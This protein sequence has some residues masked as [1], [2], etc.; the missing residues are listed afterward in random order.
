M[1]MPAKFLRPFGLTCALVLAAACS[2]PP[3]Q[4]ELT[5]EKAPPPKA[6]PMAQ[7]LAPPVPAASMDQQLLVESGIESRVAEAAHFNAARKQMLAPSYC[8]VAPPPEDRE[9]Y[10]TIEGNPI[11]RVAEN[12]VS[13]F[14]VDVDTGSY[15]N[16]RRFLQEGRLP[17]QDAVRVEELINYF[18]YA[19]APPRETKTPFSVHTEIAATPWNS[20]THLL[21]IGI[22]GWKPQRAAKASNL[23]FLIDVSGSMNEPKKLPLVKSA[24]KLLAQQLRA[25]DRVSLVV[26]AG[27]SGVVLEP[28]AGDQRT[29]IE[30]AL[31]RLEAGGS[32]N[33][34][35]GIQA[36]YALAEQAFIPSG[37][38][39]V[40]LATDGDFNV[41][42]T[43]FDSLL[44]LV[45]QK[46]QTGIALT[47]LGFGSGNYNDH[48][49]EQLADAGDG[50]H[51]YIDSLTEAQKVLVDQRDAT[52]QT[53]ARDVKIQIEF[54]PAAVAEYRLIGYENRLLRR[55]DFSNDRVD[56]GDIGAG[57]RVTA[58]YEIAL[59]G[60]GGESVDPLRYGAADEQRASKNNNS[61]LAFVRLRYKQPD[62]GMQ[63]HSRL[64]ERPVLRNQITAQPGAAWRLA[65]SVAAF[66]QLLRGGEHLHGFRYTELERLAQGA[67]G[68]DRYGYVGEFQQL[69]RLAA[70]L[71]TQAHY[72]G[73]G[74]ED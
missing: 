59:A 70:S 36:A 37:N 8:C 74:G 32:T 30:S 63:A 45:K 47:T 25:Q 52:L 38:N 60:S 6:E 12:P 35:A 44:D 23:V 49:M 4:P 21:R 57:H 64:L 53:I 46:R 41:G 5:E 14:S 39:R 43:R 65:A 16:V 31:E 51:A 9:N 58:L 48:L 2:V 40:L 11:Q 69:V 54:N 15:A 68:E 3:E 24:L 20:R 66:G 61:E 18:D 28:V 62:E 34:G 33:G 67:R 27:N 17:P 55:E 7:P 42:V 50:N 56:A 1:L 71:S 72:Q 22:Q 26:Y 13:T 10:A 73:E 29:R 19:D